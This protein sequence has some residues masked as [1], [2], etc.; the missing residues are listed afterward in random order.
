MWSLASYGLENWTQTD[1]DNGSRRN[2]KII[3]YTNIFDLC[4]KCSLKKTEIEKLGSFFFL[5]SSEAQKEHLTSG[6]VVP[7][8][9]PRC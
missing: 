8:Q 1:W 6:E 9:S 4:Y 3:L 5:F 7:D 2:I